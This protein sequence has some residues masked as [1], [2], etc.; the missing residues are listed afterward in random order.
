M[1]ADLEKVITTAEGLLHLTLHSEEGDFP[2]SLF[3][4]VATGLLA[5]L[6]PEEKDLLIVGLLQKVVSGFQTV[7]ALT[8]KPVTTVAAMSTLKAGK[9]EASPWEA[10]VLPLKTKAPTLTL[11]DKEDS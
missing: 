3:N 1:S 11:I 10:Q 9:A 6:S 7:G 2:D 5:S 4:P 8:R